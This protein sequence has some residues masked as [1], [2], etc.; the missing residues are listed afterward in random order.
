M[1][2]KR[3]ALAPNSIL[4]HT[5]Q[6]I[7]FF[8]NYFQTEY[9]Q[10]QLSLISESTGQPKFNKTNLKTIKLQIPCLEEQEKIGDFL[11]DFDEAISLA[12][13]ELEKWK[14]LKK[15]LLQQIFV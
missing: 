15:G 3:N 11:S 2:Y 12:K 13:Q 9:F 1:P 4:I 10:N 14:L 6:N 5:K 8:Y 7:V